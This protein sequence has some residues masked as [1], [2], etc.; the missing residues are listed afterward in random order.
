[1]NYKR[2]FIRVLALMF[3]LLLVSGCNLLGK[4]E[5][6]PTEEP[7]QATD[8]GEDTTVTTEKNDETTKKPD[9]TTNPNPDGGNDTP[10]PPASGKIKVACV[11]DSLT[12]GANATPYPTALQNLLGNDQYEVRNF[13]AEGRT[14][15]LGLSDPPNMPDRSYYDSKQYK[16]S[17][18]YQPDIV[19]LCLGTNDAWRVDIASKAGKSGYVQGLLKLVDSYYYD[20]GVQQVYVCLPPDCVKNNIGNLVEEHVIP[21]IEANAKDLDYK[22]ID[23]FTPTKDRSDYLQSDQLHLNTQGYAAMAQAVFQ[24]LTNTDGETDDGESGENDS[25]ENNLTFSESLDGEKI[26]DVYSF[27]EKFQ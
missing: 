21:L 5:E 25:T 27:K 10:T 1:M 22:I 15:T 9:N 8:E 4:D 19:I 11:G 16:D 26:K 17:I 20:V 6:L 2:N 23:F 14:M 3:V 12:Y 13:G 18:A 24:A 7:T